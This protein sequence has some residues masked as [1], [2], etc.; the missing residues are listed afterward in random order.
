MRLARIHRHLDQ[1]RKLRERLGDFESA[2]DDI[3]FNWRREG[4]NRWRRHFERRIAKL[5]WHESEIERLLL[6]G[7]TNPRAKTMT[8]PGGYSGPRT[9]AERAAMSRRWRPADRAPWLALLPDDT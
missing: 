6:D 3:K 9:A 5:K 8:R 1:A 7:V 4:T 2:P